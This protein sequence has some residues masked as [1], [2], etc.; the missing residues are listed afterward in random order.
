MSDGHA[1]RHGH[2]ND[3][4][5]SERRLCS[6]L[7]LTATSF[8]GEVVGSF[9]TGSLAL[10]SA[11][12][13]MATD[14]AS[15]GIAWLAIRLGRLPA[16]ERR[17]FGYRRLEILAAALNA[18]GL[19]LVAAYVFFEAV[20]RFHA[21]VAVDS[22]G[23]LWVGVAGL[24]VNA[25]AMALLRGGREE[26]LDVRGAYVEVWADLLGSAAVVVGALLIR[27]TGLAWIDPVVAI[28]IA[29]WVIPR[30]WALLRD[31]LHVLLEGTPEGIDPGAVERTILSVEGVSAVH[32]LHIWCITTGMPMLS[33]HLHVEELP[34]WDAVLAG[35]QQALARE[36]HIAHVT[37]QPE[38]AGS[39]QLQ[40]GC[41]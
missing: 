22:S 23:M 29:L 28:L 27:A 41:A 32:D 8:A 37:L 30:G 21:A 3:L 13:H 36:H 4:R 34:Q 26:S 12:G 25:A 19:F 20:A 15:L 17:S 1:H 35:V 38:V 33:A 39:C 5:G 9:V 11:A 31:A 24:A 2:A 40:S 18:A 6:A 7:L 10:L 16:D 14:V